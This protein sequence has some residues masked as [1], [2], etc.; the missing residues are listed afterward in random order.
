MMREIRDHV[1]LVTGASS[2]IGAAVA[3][4]LAEQGVH[5]GLVARDAAR[6][7]AVAARARGSR[8]TVRTYLADLAEEEDLN[9]LKAAVDDEFGRLDI[10]IHCA[11]V[12]ESGPVEDAGAD[13]LLHLFRVNTLAPYAITHLFLPAIKRRRGQIVF[14]NSRASMAAWPGMTQY[15]ATKAALRVIADGLREEVGHEGVRVLTVFPGKIATPLQHRIQEAAGRRF[16]PS[17]LPQPEDV[18]L[19]VLSALTMPVNAE[20]TDVIVRPQQDPY[21]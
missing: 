5:L 8:V 19:V 3:V 2:G 12:F 17:Q 11:G 1:A 7:E 18:A 9:S 13:L 16:D 10:L 21:V 4:K 20:I 14:I 15:A 6:L